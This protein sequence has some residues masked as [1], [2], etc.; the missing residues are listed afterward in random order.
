MYLWG[1][2]R[3]EMSNPSVLIG[4]TVNQEKWMFSKF[5]TALKNVEFNDD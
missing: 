5:C 3:F 4:S 1:N 2:T